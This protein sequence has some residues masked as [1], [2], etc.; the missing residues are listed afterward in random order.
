VTDK[1]ELRRA[2]NTAIAKTPAF[3]N[4][5]RVNYLNRLFL[6]A[7]IHECT[8]DPTGRRLSPSKAKRALNKAARGVSQR[9]M[10]RLLLKGV[11]RTPLRAAVNA[12]GLA[13]V[14]GKDGRRTQS[15]ARCDLDDFLSGLSHEAAILYV[16]PGLPGSHALDMRNPLAGEVLAGLAKRCNVS[17]A[18]MLAAVNKS[19]ARFAATFD[20]T[21]IAN[22][23]RA[24][25]RKLTR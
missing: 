25:R 23:R 1:G 11:A 5:V 20:R 9:R 14:R 10:S 19:R 18:E 2:V 24:I 22:V 21:A 16:L 8:T 3:R 7:I 17:E 6:D 4:A 15:G 13:L 12:A